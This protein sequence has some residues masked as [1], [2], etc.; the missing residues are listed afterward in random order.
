MK[1]PI[2]ETE[3]KN[4]SA[5]ELKCTR[6]GFDDIR[7]EFINDEERVFWQ[8]YVVKPCKY[9]YRLNHALQNEVATLRREIKKITLG[10]TANGTTNAAPPAQPQTQMQDGWN[11]DDPIA[12]PNAAKCYHKLY[13]TTVELT[14]IKAT[15]SSDG[16]AVVQ[17]IAKRI[18]KKEGWN[19]NNGVGFCWRVK[20]AN[21]IIVL[22]GKWNNNN[23]LV[24]DAMTDKIELKNVPLGYSID[25][26]DYQ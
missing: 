25:F 13:E 17:F 11:Y 12:H 21:N 8:T 19:G 7:T 18:G 1:C 22:T 14:G 10:G 2:C 16:K 3:I 9:A 5:S 4:S 24:G 6:C 23:L 26:V 20:D 15:R